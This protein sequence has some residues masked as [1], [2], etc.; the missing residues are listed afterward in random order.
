MLGHKVYIFD[1]DGVILNSELIHYQCYKEAIYKHA[2]VEIGWEQ[3]CKIHHSTDTSFQE[4]FL[5]KYYEIYKTKSD[6]YTKMLPNI[7]LIDGYYDFFKTL[8]KYGKEICIVTDAPRRVFDMISLKYPFLLLANVIITRELVKKRKPDSECYVKII[9]HYINRY[10]L[11]EMIA[12]EDS[13]KGWSAA[14]NVIFNCVLVN[15]D[16]YFYFKKINA[17]NTIVNFNNIENTPFIGLFDYSP[18]YISS[19]TKHREKWIGM[20]R[21]FPIQAGW[22]DINKSKSDMTNN[23]KT[24]LCSIIKQDAIDCSFGVLYTEDGEDNHIGS[25]IEIGLLLAQS[26]PIYLCGDNIFKNEVLFNFKS[27][28]NSSHADNYDL[29]N[30]F[31]DIQYDINIEYNEYKNKIMNNYMVDPQV[32]TIT[33]DVIDYIVICASGSGTRL[34]PLTKNIPKLLVNVNNDNLLYHI[35]NFWKQY[36]HKF[37][38]IVDSKYN[39]IT[40]FYLKLILDIEYQIINVDCHNK[41]ENSYTIHTALSQ[42]NI[43]NKKVLIT[44]CDIYPCTKISK[45]LFSDKNIIFTYKNLG[46][47][48]AYENIIKKK[49]NGNIIGIYYF[50]KFS[51]LTKFEAHMDIC[52]C[53]KDNFGNF[54]TYEIEELIDIGDYTKLNTY[55]SS[56]TRTYKTRYFNEITETQNNT[57]TKK[58]TCA[59]GNQVILNEICF[60]KY[61]ILNNN[62]VNLPRILEFQENKFVMSKIIGDSAIEVFNNSHIPKQFEYL[63]N[64]INSLDTL[65]KTETYVVDSDTLSTDIKIEF[66]QKVN[67][68]LENI[69]TLLRYFNYIKSVNNIQ[70]KYT[71]QHIINHMYS[72]IKQKLLIEGQ[73]YYTIHGDPHMSNILIDQKDDIYFIDPRGYFGTTKIFGIKDYDISKLVYS[74]S[75]FDHINNNNGHFFIINDNNINVNIP[76]NIDNYMFIFDKYDKELILSMT[77]LHWFGLTDYTKNHIHKCISAYYYG[78]YLYHIYY[79]NA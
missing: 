62:T 50:S 52:D 23:D 4:K 40:E 72:I 79:N 30:V 38:I 37:I 36:S 27:L 56:D 2:N 42:P 3:Y 20:R 55:H 68:R 33:T 12:F 63:Q 71:H 59:Y 35:I 19:K 10:K 9:K 25:L 21:G 58:S 60:Y 39:E 69:E 18:F 75:G 34:L 57:L 49:T 45:T 29:Y 54:D 46:R 51:R 47:Y 74:L 66:Y 77:I 1:L 8:I 76:N 26:K 53:Y 65:H 78:I 67:M 11:H 7:E 73:R 5:D 13:Y 14:S 15:N 16:S 28:I 24:Y 64:I 48:D 31:R 43:I 44:W 6:L 41:E 70:I 61:H 17:T 32:D 22:L